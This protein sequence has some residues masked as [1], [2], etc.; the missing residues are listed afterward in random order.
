MKSTRKILALLF[1]IILSSCEKDLYEDAIK[2]NERD[3]KIRT[4]T[5]EEFNSNLVQFKNIPK[6]NGKFYSSIKNNSLARESEHGVIIYMDEI[7][8][9]IKENYVSYTMYLKTPETKFNTFFN[10]TIENKNGVSSIFLTKYTTTNNWIENRE[11]KFEGQISTLRLPSNSFGS[12][13][14]ITQYI[15]DVLE[16]NDLFW[17][18]NNNSS[19]GGGG[20]SSSSNAYPWDCNG[21]V[22]TTTICIPYPCGCG[23][24]PW[25]TCHGCPQASP[26]SPGYDNVTTYECIPNST[27][28]NPPSGSNTGGTLGGGTSGGGTSGTNG[29]DNTSTGTIVGS[30][31][32]VNNSLAGDL[33]SD[34]VLDND[35]IHFKAFYEGLSQEQQQILD[36]RENQN[37]IFDYLSSNWS[38]DSQNFANEILNLANEEANQADVNSLINLTILLNNA[39]ENLYEDS[40]A[41]SLDPY[42]DIDVANYML[43]NPTD[44]L[45]MHFTIQ[46]AVLRANHQDWSDAKIYWQASKD[47]F[48]IALDMLGLVPVVGEVADLTNGVLYTL[49]GDGVNATLSVASAV[50]IAGWAAV[51]TK[52]AVKVVNASQTAVTIA[53]KVKLTWRVVGNSIDFGSSNQL[54]KVLGLAV[55]NADQA[56]HIMPWAERT[57]EVIQRAAKSGSAFHMNEALNGIAVAA[58]RNQPN[59]NVYNNTIKTKLNDYI[60][61][62]PNAT[63]QQCYNFISSLIEDVRSWVVSNPNSHLNDLVLP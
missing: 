14:E 57:H 43:T 2:N 61:D 54:R 24:W 39:G 15:E 18:D 30:P 13:A 49:E 5:F 62:H 7:K 11:Q 41:L 56:H 3:F 44:P 63:P 55:G 29:N 10:I 50:P 1:L 21:Q 42:I 45:W 6:V 52:Y 37:A 4:V 28:D 27:I 25:Q 38:D 22:I 16:D 58:W 40:F 12:T 20:G 46:C 32:G 53:T 36:I 34:G 33:N 9:I 48:H 31:D 17:G 35:E 60:L 8:E 19:S 23:D 59:H 51:G 47:I 26:Y